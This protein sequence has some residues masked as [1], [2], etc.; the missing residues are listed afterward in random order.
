LKVAG[1]HLHTH[2]LLRVFDGDREANLDAA[3]DGI[4][5]LHLAARAGLDGNLVLL[6]EPAMHD[7]DADSL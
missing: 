3:V 2:V 5:G 4:D 6:A 1:L 7:L